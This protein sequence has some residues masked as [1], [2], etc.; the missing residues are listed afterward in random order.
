MKNVLIASL[1]VPALLL[2]S[3]SDRIR[4][5]K[6]P[7]VVQNTLMQQF[8]AANSI[9]W[10]KEKQNYEAEFIKDSVEYKAIINPAG[11]LVKYKQ[12]ISS[13][14]LPAAVMQTLQTQYKDYVI[15]ELEKIGEGD[16]VYYQVEMEKGAEEVH[17]VIA[18]DGAINT[19]VRYWD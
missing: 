14:E 8:T 3:C 19:N 6:V 15:D 18:P 4:Q 1:A 13:A 5:S 7:S 10:E 12:D 9:D 16:Q 2:A 11:T 17:L